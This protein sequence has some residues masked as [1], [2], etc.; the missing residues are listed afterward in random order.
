[1]IAASSQGAGMLPVALLTG[2][3]ASYLFQGGRFVLWIW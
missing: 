2:A 3:Y 1:M